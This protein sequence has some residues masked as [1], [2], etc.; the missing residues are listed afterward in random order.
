MKQ[1][2]QRARARTPSFFSRLRNISL[3]AVAVA[4]ALLTAPLVLPELVTTAAGY[5][6]TAGTVASVISQLTVQG[7][8]VE[9]PQNPSSEGGA[10]GNTLS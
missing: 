9:A 4:T 2:M 5:L 3:V 8:G 6:F 1:I 10:D 7:E